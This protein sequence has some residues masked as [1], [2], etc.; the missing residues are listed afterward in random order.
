MGA[1]SPT[2]MVDPNPPRMIPSV[3]EVLRTVR[4]PDELVE[5]LL[6]RFQTIQEEGGQPTTER[7][8]GRSLHSF[9]SHLASW[10]EPVLGLER[11]SLLE[12]DQDLTVHL[13]HLLFS[14]PVD[15]YST[16]RQL[17]ACLEELPDK[18]F[19]LV[20][21][22]LVEASVLW[23][24]VRAVPRPDHVNHLEGVIPTVWPFM[25]CKRAVKLSDGGATS[26]VGG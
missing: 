14:V 17:F 16:G 24:S 21:K 12:V 13:L 5:A 6:G 15:L 7:R 11:L 25:P 20:V 3:G 26:C 23:R 9:L 22:K 4:L 1:C 10:F 18:G 8:T 19:P 2:V